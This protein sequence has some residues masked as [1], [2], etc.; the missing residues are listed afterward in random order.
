MFEVHIQHDWPSRMYR[1]YLVDRRQSRALLHRG[2]GV[3]K[4][5]DPV[6]SFASD[7]AAP[8][9]RLP[10]EAAPA[11]LGALARQLGAVEH[12]EQLRR[13]YEAERGRVDKFIDHLV[14]HV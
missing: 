6:V 9:M 12:P 11:L 7:F 5:I 2:D 14:G 3:V 10:E 8:I 1:V 13:D 4:E